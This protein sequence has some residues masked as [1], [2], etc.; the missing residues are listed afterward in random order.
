MMRPYE[1]KAQ[2]YETDQMKVVHHSNYIRWFEEART[3]FMGQIG[4]PY[5]Q[6]EEKGIIVPVLSV[7]CDYKSMTRFEEVVEVYTYVKKF[8]GIRMEFSYEIRDKKTGE[9]RVTGESGHCFLDPD[10][11]LLSIKKKFPDYFKVYKSYEGKTDLY[12]EGKGY[13]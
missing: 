13:E 6:M 2:Y 12:E 8:N 11:H 9:V 7:K 1:H 4:L 10:Y 5:R 3:D